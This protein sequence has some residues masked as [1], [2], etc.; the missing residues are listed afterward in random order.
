MRRH[1]HRDNKPATTRPAEARGRNSSWV[2]AKPYRHGEQT[3]S[4]RIRNTSA[5]CRTGIRV[6][7]IP[8]RT[9]SASYP[10]A[11]Q[12]DRLHLS[13]PRSPIFFMETQPCPTTSPRW[14]RERLGREGTR[15]PSSGVPAHGSGPHHAR[16]AAA[17]PPNGLRGEARGVWTSE[18]QF[19]RRPLACGRTGDCLVPGGSTSSFKAGKRVNSSCRAGFAGQ[20]THLSEITVV[21]RRRATTEPGRCRGGHPP[22]LLAGFEVVRR[23]CCRSRTGDPGRTNGEAGFIACE[24]PLRPGSRPVPSP[25]VDPAMPRP[26]SCRQH[27]RLADD[28]RC[29]ARYSSYFQP[30]S[31]ASLW[32]VAAQAMLVSI[33]TDG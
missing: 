28:Q 26:P 15:L 5:S 32:V 4:V 21:D 25:E 16:T 13:L 17:F 24:S 30:C 23:C 3:T 7:R 14:G 11:S 1:S 18:A 10:L 20:T 12:F 33:S 29:T 19:S 9:V 31:T 2:A 8:G 6:R 22:F 27:T